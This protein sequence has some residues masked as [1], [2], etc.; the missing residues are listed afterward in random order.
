[1]DE[2]L[3]EDW[4]DARLRDEARY[5]D[6][7]GFTAR[8]VQKLPGAGQSR[9]R[10]RAVI[11]LGITLLRLRACLSALRWRAVSSPIGGLSLR[12][13]AAGLRSVSS[14]SAATL[15]ATAVADQCRARARRAATR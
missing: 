10:S 15:I 14:P 5:I 7:D 2:Q 9:T 8:V 13:D 11:L 6:D 4:L 12:L 1:M 3:Q